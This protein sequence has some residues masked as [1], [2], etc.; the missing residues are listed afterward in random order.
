MTGQLAICARAN[1]RRPRESVDATGL[2]EAFWPAEAVED[3]RPDPEITCPEP[4][5]ARAMVRFDQGPAGLGVRPVL[6][7]EYHAEPG[8]LRLGLDCPAA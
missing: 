1:R 7:C 8:D 2:C 6:V 4:A 3:G 5:V